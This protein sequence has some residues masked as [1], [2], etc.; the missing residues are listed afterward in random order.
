MLIEQIIRRYSLTNMVSYFC[1]M[2]E[3]SRVDIML[4]YRLKAFDLLSKR[5]IGRIMNSLIKYLRE[6]RRRLAPS[7]SK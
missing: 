7:P 2:A 1:E 6:R 4:G 5:K 3:V